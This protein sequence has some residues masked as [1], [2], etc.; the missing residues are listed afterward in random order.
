MDTYGHLLPNQHAEAVGGMA[1][2]MNGETPLA[3]TGTA[4]NATAVQTAVGT[5]NSAKP[6]GSVQPDGENADMQHTLEFPQQTALRKAKKRIGPT[7]IRTEN[8]GI[9]SP[10]LCR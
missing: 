5:Q 4:G 1:A 9:M 10:L 8:Q 3:A 2:M 7:R 6:C